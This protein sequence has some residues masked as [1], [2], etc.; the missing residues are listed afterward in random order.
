[1]KLR[2][3]ILILIA[4][5]AFFV[6]LNGAIYYYCTRPCLTDRSAGMQAKSIELDK[7]LP[8]RADSGIVK[9]K[10]HCEMSG[11]LPSLDGA[12]ALY[13][14]YSAFVNAVYPSSS[15]SFNGKDFDAG[16]KLHMNNTPGAYKEIVD[17]DID[18]AFCAR[19]SSEQLQ[20]ARDK[21]VKLELVPIGYE[22][23]VFIVNSK[24]PLNGLTSEEIRGI[25]SGRYT[26]WSQLGG[27]SE[28]INALQRNAGSGSQTALLGFMK[29]TKIN[30]SYLGFMGSPIGFSFRYY[31]GGVVKHGNVKMLSVDG[32]YPSTANI[33]NGK[34]PLVSNFYAVYNKSNQNPNI[35]PLLKWILS[36][37]GQKIIKET[38]YVPLR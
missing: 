12:A 21:G 38:G 7:Y 6:A 3:Q 5:A 18:I 30:R 26:R 13:P 22:A 16:S 11:D 15:V 29:G 24:N 23:F 37:D 2:K 34:Y 20:Y 4:V 19:P 10:S 36:E 31:V 35:Q 25:Y 14:V 8:F 32:V 33:A 1:M 28:M 27:R 17:G 9:I